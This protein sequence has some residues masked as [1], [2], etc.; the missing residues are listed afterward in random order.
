MKL[1]EPGK[2][3]KRTGCLVCGK[4][5]IYETESSAR[6]CRVCG[7]SVESNAVCVDGHFVCDKCHASSI[8]DYLW[9]LR[10]TD[11]KDP[12]KLFNRIASLESVL[13]RKI[14]L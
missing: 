13:L 6:I 7:G 12:V 1:H 5:I 3:G 2:R 9:L 8:R 14:H 10:R 11:E 4:P